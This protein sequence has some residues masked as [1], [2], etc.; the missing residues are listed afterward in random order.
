MLSKHVRVLEMN[1]K[2]AP[3]LNFM[4]LKTLH[5]RPSEQLIVQQA[6]SMRTNESLSVAHH[7]LSYFDSAGSPPAA[8]FR[9]SCSCCSKQTVRK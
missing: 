8:S 5:M 9:H 2:N 4:S 7:H 3:K 1:P 6:S